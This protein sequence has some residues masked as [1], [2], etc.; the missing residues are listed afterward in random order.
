MSLSTNVSGIVYSQKG[1]AASF[2]NVGPNIN[3]S[4]PLGTVGGWQIYATGSTGG[5]FT[6]LRTQLINT[7]G[8]GFTG[9]SYSIINNNNGYSGDTGTTGVTG[10]TGEKRSCWTYR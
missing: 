3:S 4:A 9:P 6:D 7:S 8:S 10:P 5:Y 2:L 1:F